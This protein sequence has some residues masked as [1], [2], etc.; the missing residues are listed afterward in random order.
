MRTEVLGGITTLATMAYILVVNPAMLSLAG[1]PA[2]AAT[3]ATIVV[4]AFG[5]LLLGLY[6]NRP[7]AVAPHMGEN[8]FVAFSLAAMGI[9]WPEMLGAVFVSGL[10]F[11][12]ITLLGVRAWAAGR[13]WDVK[14][15]A[16]VLAAL[17]AS[18]CLFGLLH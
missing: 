9:A 6:A 1:S 14:P 3:V 17:C 13:R 15:G 18:Y 12:A 8:A 5:T 2:G 10:A 11:V 16:R 7:I 4:A